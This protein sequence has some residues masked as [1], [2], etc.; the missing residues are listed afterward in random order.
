MIIAYTSPP[1]EDFN[2]TSA[3][4]IQFRG[5]A[6]GGNEDEDR[7]YINYEEDE[8]HQKPVYPSISVLR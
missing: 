8:N 2:D 7:V 5:N 6:G 1:C 3:Q 4:V